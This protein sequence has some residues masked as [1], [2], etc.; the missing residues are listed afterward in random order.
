MRV[1]LFG[2]TGMVGAGTLRECL[3]DARVS[4][5]VALVR[6]PTGTTNAKLREILHTDFLHY[7]GLQAEFVRADACFFCLGVSSA[8][9]SEA[10]YTRLTFD[11]TMAAAQ[12]MA[13]ANPRMVF[14]YVSGEGTD[15]TERGRTM[16]ARVKGRTENAIL[17]LPFRAAYMFRPG[18]IQPMHGIRSKTGWVQAALV[19]LA[20][21]YPLIRRIAPRYTTT[22]E[23]L[24]R[25]F[26]EVA[27]AG[28]SKNV[29]DT[30]DINAIGSRGK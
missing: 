16:W 13:A 14:C 22:T 20:P 6:S 25:A 9:K 19:V 5:V 7:D 23:I 30:R 15:S 28:Y 2:A 10:D 26:I 17:A 8:G 24:G 21:L 27:A 11:L 18:F 3:L 1:V 12:A 4:E 29:L